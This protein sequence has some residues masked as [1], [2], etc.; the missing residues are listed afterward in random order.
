MDSATELRPEQ[1]RAL[2]YISRHGTEAPFAEIR[3][4]VAKTFADLAARLDSL[5]EETV[6]KKPA[7]AAWSVQEVVDHLVE[8]NRPAIGELESLLAGREPA[9]GPIPASLQSAAPL[10]RPWR[11]LAEE[12]KRV[13]ARFLATLDGASEATPQQA[14]APVVMVVKCALGDGSLEP[15]H[16]VQS[17][18]W[19]AYALLVRVHT[20]EHLHQIERSLAAVG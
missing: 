17:F 16:W 10:A 13:N 4:R 15:V 18:D 3:R 1:A 11:E 14:R 8:S 12:L 2:E 20:L 6:G 19:K 9:G 7:P 5:P